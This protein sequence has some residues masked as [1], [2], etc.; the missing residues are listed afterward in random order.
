MIMKTTVVILVTLG[1]RVQYTSPFHHL[2]FQSISTAFSLM[3]PAFWKQIIPKTSEKVDYIICIYAH[4]LQ[5]WTYELSL[6][7]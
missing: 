7:I 1:Y 2:S 5:T 3:F 6:K 4:H